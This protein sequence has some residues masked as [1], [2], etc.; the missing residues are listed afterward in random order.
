MKLL[1]GLLGLLM[2]AANEWADAIDCDSLQPFDDAKTNC[3]DTLQ[4]KCECKRTICNVCDGMERN[5]VSCINS[6]FNDP[7]LLAHLPNNTQVYNT[8]I[9][10]AY[11]ICK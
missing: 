11:M 4:G 1:L 8:Y 7:D 3:G 5:V 9:L 10:I 6:N 2:V